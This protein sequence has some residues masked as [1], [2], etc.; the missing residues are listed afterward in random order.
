MNAYQPLYIS[1]NLRQRK[2]LPESKMHLD[3]WIINDL[4]ESFD[5]LTIKLSIDGLQIHKIGN[6]KIDTDSIHHIN[7]ENFRIDF[8]ESI[9]YGN[10]T[11]HFDLVNETTKKVISK[12][13]A[14]IEIVSKVNFAQ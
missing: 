7:W 14:S 4:H 5:E 10:Y 12:N 1:I 8:P 3:L 6:L 9:T 2:Y 13:S 11:I